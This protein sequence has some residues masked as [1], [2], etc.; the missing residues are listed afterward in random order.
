MWKT[1]AKVDQVKCPFCGFLDTRVVDSRTTETG[2][3]IRRR[4]EC[5]ECSQRF[6]TYERREDIPLTVIKK[7]GVRELFNRDKLLAGI[8]RATVKRRIAREE[9]ER[10]VAEI[11]SALRNQ[12]RYEVTSKELG[13]VV[14]KHLKKLDKVA[15]VR[16]ASVYREFQDLKEFTE[17]LEKLQ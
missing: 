8:L 2:D 3:A 11:E 4:R 7:S 16:F 15:Y 6:T 12:F 5:D 10:V 14:L 9:L 1:V 17:E 13:E